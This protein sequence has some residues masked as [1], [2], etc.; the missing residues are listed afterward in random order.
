MLRMIAALVAVACSGSVALAGSP[1]RWEGLSPYA[2]YR[3]SLIAEGWQ[4]EELPNAYIDGLPE[5]LCGSGLCIATWN[6]PDGEVVEM[7]LW[8]D[9]DDQ[10]ILAPEWQ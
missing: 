2:P 3:A 7:A 5:V 1:P 10:L 9:D 4:P 8:R 6:A